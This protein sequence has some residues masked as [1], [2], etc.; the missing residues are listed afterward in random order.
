MQAAPAFT[1]EL[2]SVPPSAEL[3]IDLTDTSFL[4]SNGIRVLIRALNRQDEGG[5]SLVL[6]KPRASV[7][8]VLE[9]CGLDDR[10]TIRR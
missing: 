2:D 4:D 3:V 10:F 7:F 6:N 9:L 5:G 1:E 8:R